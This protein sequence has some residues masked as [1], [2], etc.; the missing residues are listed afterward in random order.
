VNRE[1]VAQSRLAGMTEVATGVLHNVGNVLNSVNVSA[2]LA[3]DR[4]RNSKVASLGRAAALL[5][6]QP[7]AAAAFIA[8]DPK[9]RQ[10]PGFFAALAGQLAAEREQLVA[11]LRGLQANVEHIK[12]IVAM[13]QSYAT[14]SGV[15]ERLPLADLVEDAL[16]L[17]DASLHRHGI[18][19]VREFSPV[20]PA[21][22]DRHKVLQILINLIGNAKHALE[23]RAEG[24]RLTLRLAPAGG[25]VRLDVEDNGIGI[26]AEN[27]GR[28]FS[29]G[30]T[31]KKT[32]HGFGLHSCALAAKELGGS[33]AARSEGPGRGATFTLELPVPITPDHA[34]AA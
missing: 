33:L 6:A 17:C 18:E 14:V 30:F 1:L 4:A 5:P 20:A 3:L 24:R 25:Q 32:G 8:S 2:N 28:I 34:I 7:D 16:Q 29:H 10:L 27:L 26:P 31:T 13:Q 11:E 22:V 19:V 15:L 23:S 9:G 12:Q 21:L